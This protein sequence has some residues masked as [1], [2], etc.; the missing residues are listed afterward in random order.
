[1]Q[2]PSGF[3]LNFVFM[4]LPATFMPRRCSE[5]KVIVH[6][7]M[8]L[9]LVVLPK[10]SSKFSKAAFILLKLSYS[11]EASEQEPLNYGENK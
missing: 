9:S 4:K 11:L 10:L 3:T 7:I 5:L 2:V 8:E 6:Q 1:M